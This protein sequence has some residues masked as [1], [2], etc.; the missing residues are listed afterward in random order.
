METLCS[1]ATS[2]D[3]GLER[4]TGASETVMEQCRYQL[5][6]SCRA[7]GL[8]AP[9]DTVFPVLDGE[10]ALLSRA[11]RARNMGFADML[12]IHPRQ[13]APVQA[14]FSPDPD[15]VEWARK[16]MEA[17]RSG[18]GAFKV[19]GQMVDAPVIAMARTILERAESPL[20]K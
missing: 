8:L 16:V 2:D 5:L 11:R 15:Q 9:I 13:I 18:D 10:E 6:V 14:E 7:A 4:N 19:D 17:A 3:L 12:C 1:G 20:D